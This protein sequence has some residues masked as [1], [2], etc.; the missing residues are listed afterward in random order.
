MIELVNWH[1]VQ[2]RLMPK[3]LRPWLAEKGSLTRRLRRFNQVDFSVQLL[4]NSWIKPLADES[5]KLNLAMSALAYQREVLLMDGDRANVY[6]RTIIPQQTYQSMPHLFNRLGGRSLGDMLFSHPSVERGPIEI[7]RL[8]PGQWLYEVAL[9][10]QYDRPEYLWGR[11]SVMYLKGMPLL[12]N[13]FFLPA[14][15]IS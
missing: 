7:A 8:R 4:G 2:R 6:A 9:F 14:I 10:E 5:L 11:R 15:E 3:A 13:E 1:P 12:I